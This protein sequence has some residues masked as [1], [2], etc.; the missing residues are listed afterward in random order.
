MSGLVK[1]AA[2][3]SIKSRCAHQCSRLNASQSRYS[4]SYRGKFFSP[5]LCY[6]LPGWRELLTEME[7]VFSDD[8]SGK[9]L[10]TEPVSLILRVENGGIVVELY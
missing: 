8:V 7:K 2:W 5:V 1:N 6:T 3:R 10:L 9:S 4:T